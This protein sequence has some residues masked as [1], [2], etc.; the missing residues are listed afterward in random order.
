LAPS[1]AIDQVRAMPTSRS[2]GSLVAALL[3]GSLGAGCHP[4]APVFEANTAPHIE[5]QGSNPEADAG[6]DLPHAGDAGEA[7]AGSL[8]AGPPTPMGC[9][10]YEANDILATAVAL[11]PGL[12]PGLALCGSDIDLFTVQVPA[13]HV[14][15]AR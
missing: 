11:E 10:A 15:T 9:D 6:V 5:F 14:L 13:Q 3:A 12:Y 7:D 4:E 2:P 8:D 1:R